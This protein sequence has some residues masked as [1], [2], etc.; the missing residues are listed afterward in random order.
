MTEELSKADMA[1]NEVRVGDCIAFV[2]GS[3]RAYMGFGRIVGFTKRG[4]KVAEA[5]LAR[6]I[7]IPVTLESGY[8]T[9]KYEPAPEHWQIDR[10][11]EVRNLK[12]TLIIGMQ[13][14]PKEVFIL[15]DGLEIK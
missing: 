7:R 13:S 6:Y 9:F 3:R 14:L 10:V 8:K 2:K 1:G 15:L 12:K 11:R 4:I 5:V